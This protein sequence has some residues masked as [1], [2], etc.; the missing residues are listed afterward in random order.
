MTLKRKKGHSNTLT[1]FCFEN[2]AQ[3]IDQLEEAVVTDAEERTTPRRI[4][5]DIEQFEKF[6]EEHIND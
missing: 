6:I 1:T 3:I 2:A 4:L 5:M